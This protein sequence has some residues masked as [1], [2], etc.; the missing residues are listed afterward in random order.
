MALRRM[1]VE[2]LLD[3]CSCISSDY[4]VPVGLLIVKLKS[5]DCPTAFKRNPW[6]MGVSLS[7]NEGLKPNYQLPLKWLIIGAL[8]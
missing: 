8:T 2:S 1:P 7:K 3:C 4:R 5:G 6:G